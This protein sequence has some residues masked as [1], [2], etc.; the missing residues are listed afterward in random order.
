MYVPGA[1][2]GQRIPGTG[3]KGDVCWEANLGPLQECSTLDRRHPAA[4]HDNLIPRHTETE[5]P[6]S[7][8]S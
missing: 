3:V 4:P 7:I 1:H 8:L 2:G 5:S 6:M